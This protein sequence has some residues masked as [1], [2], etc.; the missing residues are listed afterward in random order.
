MPFRLEQAI[1][2]DLSVAKCGATKEAALR[3]LAR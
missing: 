1:R 2:A 3:G